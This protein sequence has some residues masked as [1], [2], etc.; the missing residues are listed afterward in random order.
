MRYSQ[1][2]KDNVVARLLSKELSISEAVE[3]YSIGK[4]TKLMA[5]LKLP[6]GVTYLQ[7]HTAVNAKAFMSET[8]FG[9]FC[10]KHGYL[11]STVDAWT[12]WFNNHPDVVDKKRHDAQMSAMSELKKENARK[13]REIARKDK[14]LADAATMLML[15]KKAEA[16]WGAKES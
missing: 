4:S 9:Q 10:R 7:A 2:F 13:D 11:A 16:I 1:E 6:K 3:Q 8:D 15:S 14:A 5:S 12:E